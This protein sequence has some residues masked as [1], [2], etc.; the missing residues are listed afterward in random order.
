MT[1]QAPSSPYLANDLWW[2][3]LPFVLDSTEYTNISLVSK[4]FNKI[5]LQCIYDQDLALKLATTRPREFKRLPSHFSKESLFTCMT[6]RKTPLHWNKIEINLE[7]PEF[8][9]TLKCMV[10]SWAFHRPKSIPRIHSSI[11]T[12]SSLMKEVQKTQER[13]RRSKQN[14]MT[15]TAE[16]YNEMSLVEARQVYSLYLTL[17]EGHGI[18]NKW[19]VLDA[20]NRDAQSL[21]FASWELK[22]NRKIVLTAVKQNPDSFIYANDDLRNNREFVLKLVKEYPSALKHASDILIE[23]QDFLSE[24]ILQ[25][26]KCLEFI[27]EPVHS[28]LKNKLLVMQIHE[29]ISTLVNYCK[30]WDHRSQ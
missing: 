15:L 14:S 18:H 22:N 1:V 11:T 30:L 21:Q 13:V 4:Y 28:D 16:E 24:A 8:I 6:L 2:N 29:R 25:N 12:N 5:A 27:N 19:L 10:A 7:N 20:V 9:H 26:P 3:I 17:R 23:N